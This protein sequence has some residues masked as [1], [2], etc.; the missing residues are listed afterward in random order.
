M[1]LVIKK[2]D[3]RIK[4]EKKIKKTDKEIDEFV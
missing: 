1:K 4:I 2:I 3:E